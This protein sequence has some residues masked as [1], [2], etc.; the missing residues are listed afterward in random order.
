MGTPYYL[1]PEVLKD[2]GYDYKADI[3]SVGITTLEMA[4][5]NPYAELHPMRVLM[6][7]SNSPAPGLTKDSWSRE[8][9]SFVNACLELNPKNRPN[10]QELLKHP[11]LAKADVSTL[12]PLIQEAAEVVDFFGGVE[13][14]RIARKPPSAPESEANSSA[15]NF[16][17]TMDSLTTP[18]PRVGISAIGTSTGITDSLS[19]ASTSR[20][21][22]DGG[23]DDDDDE[24][25]S[26]E[27]NCGSGSSFLHDLLG[28][29]PHSSSSSSGSPNFRISTKEDIDISSFVGPRLTTREIPITPKRG[30]SS[31][32]CLFASA[33]APSVGTITMPKKPSFSRLAS[34]CKSLPDLPS[35]TATI[36]AQ[37]ET[38]LSSEQRHGSCA[39]MSADVP[40]KYATIEI[41]GKSTS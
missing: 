3:W 40:I 22:F 5:K 13:K 4:E 37:A 30:T 41:S 7:L 28:S 31:D 29:R 23:D 9:H 32:A 15:D 1:A 34:F 25:D 38:S 20:T 24:D 14:A 8:F 39:P 16:D 35:Y 19:G 10:A 36:K 6:V 18:R 33:S 21:S 11:F 27:E 2:Q 12:M 26:D 17:F